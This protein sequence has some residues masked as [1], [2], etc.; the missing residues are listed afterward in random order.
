MREYIEELVYEAQYAPL[1][2]RA[3]VRREVAKKLTQAIEDT[4]KTYFKLKRI[5]DANKQKSAA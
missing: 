5:Q 1:G 4:A 3:A 2:Q